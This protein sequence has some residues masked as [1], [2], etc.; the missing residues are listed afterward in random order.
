MKLPWVSRLAYETVVEERDRLREQNDSLIDGLTRIQRFQ[1]GL[2]ETP[3]PE[4]KQVEPMPRELEE[5]CLK[6]GDPAI[7]QQTKREMYRRHQ[8]GTPWSE[9]VRELVQEE[10]GNGAAP[11]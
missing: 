9:M 7:R 4:R 2:A 3:R 8:R 11:R 5:Y 6:I 1:A 10:A